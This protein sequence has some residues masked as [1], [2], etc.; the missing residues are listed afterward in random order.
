ML[1]E[2][3]DKTPL[4]QLTPPEITKQGVEMVALC[5]RAP[6]TETP[7]K[8]AAREKLFSEKYDTQAK[9][10]L[11]EARRNSMIEYRK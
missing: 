10:Y 3:L 1:R 8:R 11:N 9:K 2:L 6:S 7:E 5:G 4:G